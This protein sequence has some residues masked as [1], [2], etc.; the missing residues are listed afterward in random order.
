MRTKALL[1]CVVLVALASLA[2]IPIDAATT[3]AT[4]AS[5][6]CRVY[7]RVGDDI[8]YRSCQCDDVTGKP[9]AC[10]IVETCWHDVIPPNLGN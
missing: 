2:P 6:S 7:R 4:Q 3:I 5:H 1:L 10:S 9:F 8:C